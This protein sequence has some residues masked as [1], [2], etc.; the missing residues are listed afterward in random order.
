MK[1]LENNLKNKNIK[2][3]CEF[4]IVYNKNTITYILIVFLLYI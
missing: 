2:Y 1:A 4:T 3:S